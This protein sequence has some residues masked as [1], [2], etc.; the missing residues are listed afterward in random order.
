MP[1]IEKIEFHDEGFI[2][3]LK[4]EG[5]RNLITEL[6]TQRYGMC[7]EG[8]EMSVDEIR[9]RVA[10]EIRAV[11]RKAKKDNLENNTLAKVVSA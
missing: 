3:V 9:T 10:G 7:G 6:T 4:S 2:A 5:V 8:Y 11:T 1:T